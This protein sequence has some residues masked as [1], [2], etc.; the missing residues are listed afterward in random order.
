MRDRK[1]II[2]IGAGLG[3]LSAAIR[4]ANSGAR[5][6]VYERLDRPGGK[7]GERR[8][9][10]F[11]WDTGP[12]VITMRPVYEQLFREAGRDLNDYVQLKPLEPI[13]RYFW[14]DGLQLNATSNEDAM[15]AQIETFAP[16]DVDGYRQFMRYA[17]RL[18]DT[19]QAPFLF[20]QQPTLRDL[21][22]L[23]LADVFKI[24]AMR[25][26]H[27]AIAA[28][29]HDPH[30]VQLFDRFAT[31]NGSSPFQAPATL[32]VIAH[33]EMAM[34]AWYPQG[35]VYQLARAYARL[36]EEMGVELHYGAAVAEI[37]LH[38]RRAWGVRLETGETLK[39]DA[40][41]CNADVSWAYQTLLPNMTARPNLR[42]EPS[43]S[44][45]VQL[46]GLQAQ[47]AALAHHNIFFNEPENYA[48][49]FADIFAQHVPPAD[50]TL[51]VCITAKS[52][53]GHAPAHGENWFVLV[54]APYLSPAYDW[55][56]QGGRYDEHITAQ[57]EGRMAHLGHTQ[58]RENVVSRQSLTPQDL[59]H[60]YGGNRGSIYGFSSN[61]KL[62]AFARP[63][64]RARGIDGLYFAGGSAH[65]GGGVPL[66][67]LS[68]AAAA[69]CVLED[70]SG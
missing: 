51:Y 70:L 25:T 18:Y 28:H 45:F 17:K 58:W 6:S 34:G 1:H 27:Q 49:E 30:L 56:A 44:G 40:V 60:A 20:R 53:P 63:N 54:N 14:P 43:C 8:Q 59:Q 52:D 2:V 37:N 22:R 38:G 29:F 62:A 69:A 21:L 61:T 66:V 41:I 57:L 67:T 65:P 33:V 48:A 15:C 4:L 64:N 9:G 50:P 7:M 42:L 31:Y 36:A 13:T 23:P 5:V 16:S 3:G 46:L 47:H 68:G 19:I 24:D 39:A 10:E 35:G 11:R 55:R 26:M 32:N 12:S